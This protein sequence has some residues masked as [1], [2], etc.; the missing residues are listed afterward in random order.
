MM[1]NVKSLNSYIKIGKSD[2][3]FCRKTSKQIQTNSKESNE[4][5]DNKSFKE[6]YINLNIHHNRIV[7]N[8]KDKEFQPCLPNSSFFIFHKC[9]QNNKIQRYLLLE[10]NHN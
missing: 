2:V 5:E 10:I 3:Q 7:K 6:K 8:N 9:H 1:Q 4:K